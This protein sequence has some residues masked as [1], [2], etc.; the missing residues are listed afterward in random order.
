VIVI[1]RTKQQATAPRVFTAQSFRATPYACS[2][3]PLQC[4]RRV[5]DSAA[6]RI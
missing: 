1:K 5:F 2:E 6:K 4:A 3:S